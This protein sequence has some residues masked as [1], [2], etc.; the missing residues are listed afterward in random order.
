MGAPAR[1][2][3]VKGIE[4]SC[5]AWKADVLPLNY[6]RAGGVLRVMRVRH[7]ARPSASLRD[8]GAL[9]RPASRLGPL[10]RASRGVETVG[11]VGGAGFEP[12]KAVPADLQSAPVD[13]LGIRPVRARDPGG[14]SEC[15]AA[16]DCRG[17]AP[18]TSRRRDRDESEQ[19]A[20]VRPGRVGGDGV[21]RPLGPSVIVLESRRRRGASDGTRTHNHLITNQ[22]LYQ[23]SHAG[24]A[25]RTDAH[26]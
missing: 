26:R 6:T 18:D 8:C 4:P 19:P 7:T 1:M 9:Q 17:V 22:V 21:R 16:A 3:R 10:R 2:E 11:L 25:V 5:S 20:A 12:A 14:R 15:D 13:R 24:N 23:L